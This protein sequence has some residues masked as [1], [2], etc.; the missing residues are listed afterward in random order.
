MNESFAFI[1]ELQAD[2]SN[3]MTADSRTKA[4]ESQQ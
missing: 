4:I 2:E 1:K 3:T